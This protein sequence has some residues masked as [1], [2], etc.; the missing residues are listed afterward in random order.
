MLRE[1][2]LLQMS[3]EGIQSVLAE[4]GASKSNVLRFGMCS[5]SLANMIDMLSDVRSPAVS[6]LN[7]LEKDSG[8]SR[9]PKSLNEVFIPI[10]PS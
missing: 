3:A 2:E 1:F 8:Y 6:F 7:N 10:I 5:L 4:C 9:W